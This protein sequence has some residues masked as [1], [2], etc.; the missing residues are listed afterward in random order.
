[1]TE[2]R[3][4]VENRQV[5]P[6]DYLRYLNQEQRAMAEAYNE[7][8]KTVALQ[9]TYAAINTAQDVFDVAMGY[10][11][12]YHQDDSFYQLISAA[13]PLILYRNYP[14]MIDTGSAVFSPMDRKVNS[15][16][17][18]NYE[19]EQHRAGI[20]SY[21]TFTM[22]EY[23]TLTE[24][25]LSSLGQSQLLVLTGIHAEI[26][27]CVL[28]REIISD[29]VLEQIGQEYS[30]L[31]R[32]YNEQTLLLKEAY[33]KK[34]RGWFDYFHDVEGEICD[35]STDPFHNRFLERLSYIV[36]YE[37]Y[38]QL[39]HSDPVVSIIAAFEG[40]GSASLWA[41]MYHED[42]YVG[43]E[44]AKQVQAYLDLVNE[45]LDGLEDPFFV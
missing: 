21:E 19:I 28:N 1:M 37:N 13:A 15:Y 44:L 5:I 18:L 41:S 10:H 17:K 4:F 20:D 34:F 33:T 40:G 45:I 31:L 36:L 7:Q 26:A 2:A 11:A 23:F 24:Q 3:E 16:G 8:T 43:E 22:E 35:Y 38:S 27:D 39:S 32:Q 29:A 6:Y 14:E 30:E 12:A 9:G 25:L 42:W